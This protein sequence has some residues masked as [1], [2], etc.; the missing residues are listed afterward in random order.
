MKIY[1]LLLTFMYFKELFY[2]FYVPYCFDNNLV[3]YNFVLY[4]QKTALNGLDK[5]QKGS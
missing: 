4:L 5:Q 1:N 2:S 3:L